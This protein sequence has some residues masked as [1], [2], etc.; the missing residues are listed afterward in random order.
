MED[1]VGELVLAPFD[2]HLAILLRAICPRLLFW[3]MGKKAQKE[4][5]ARTAAA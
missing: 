4:A 1:G 3:Y 5:R 2:A